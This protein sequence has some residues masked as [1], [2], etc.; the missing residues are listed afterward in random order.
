MGKTVIKRALDAGIKKPI[1]Y[2]VTEPVNKN[3]TINK[4]FIN[5]KQVTLLG[6]VIIILLFFNFKNILKLKF[7]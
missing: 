2:F 4:E 6:A 1:F 5:F 7:C 3:G